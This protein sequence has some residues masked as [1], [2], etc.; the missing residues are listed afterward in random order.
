[1]R[2][3]P[4]KMGSFFVEFFIILSILNMYGKKDYLY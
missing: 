3:D 1:M 2:E 4:M